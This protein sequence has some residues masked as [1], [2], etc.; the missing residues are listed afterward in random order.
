LIDNVLE[1][2]HP[3]DAQ[4]AVLQHNP[5]PVLHRVSNHLL[6][7]GPLPLPKRD[8]LDALTSETSCVGELE[9]L[10][11]AEAEVVGG[12]KWLG[13]GRRRV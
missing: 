7:D 2:W 6:G 5:C 8:A 10:L 1:A 3:L 11:I 9:Q 12:D 13:G 4:V